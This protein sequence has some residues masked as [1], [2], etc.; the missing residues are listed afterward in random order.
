M[1]T[2]GAAYHPQYRLFRGY[3]YLTADDSSLLPW[4]T[5]KTGVDE[6]SSVFRRVQSEM[7]DALRMVQAVINRAKTERQD[8]DPKDRPVLAA[9]TAA[10]SM[11][12][13]NVPTSDTFA[14]PADPPRTR[15]KASTTKKIVYSVEVSAFKQVAEELD[16]DSGADVGRRTFQYYLE[17]E[18]P[19]D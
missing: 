13:D 15:S 1:G 14:V 5:T 2:A 3:V 8:R 18:V 11:T 7:F 10:P 17:R 16:T 4:N 12:L 6:D 9:M 19:E